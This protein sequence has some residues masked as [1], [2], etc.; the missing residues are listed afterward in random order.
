MDFVNKTFYDQTKQQTL[1]FLSVDLDKNIFRLKSRIKTEDCKSLSGIFRLPS[2]WWCHVMSLTAVW[3]VVY[4]K[5]KLWLV[6]NLCLWQ[7][8]FFVMSV[9]TV[10]MLTPAAWI[11]HHLPEYRQRARQRP[12]TWTSS[13]S[14]SF[15]FVM[16]RSCFK[17][18]RFQY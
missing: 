3:F 5:M 9:F 15:H 11:L 18:C 17:I 16:N 7:Q 13:S 2:P 4:K 12:K 14:S 6:F 8:S 1:C 10:A